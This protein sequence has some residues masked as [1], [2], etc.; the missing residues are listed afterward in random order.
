MK[1]R[2]KNVVVYKLKTFSYFIF[3]M[4]GDIFE[5]YKTNKYA[6]A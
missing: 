3:G 4:Q 1:Y 5:E 6:S 2:V